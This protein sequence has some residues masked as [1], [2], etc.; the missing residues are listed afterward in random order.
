MLLWVIGMGFE[1]TCS[2]S[3]KGNVTR[4]IPKIYGWEYK[5][6]RLAQLSV[7]LWVPN[8]G[9]CQSAGSQSVVITGGSQLGGPQFESYG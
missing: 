9:Y 3:G 7:G 8:Q 1:N 2:V 5:L 4:I 6:L